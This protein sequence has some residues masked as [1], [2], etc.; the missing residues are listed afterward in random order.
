M[1]IHILYNF[2][3]EPWGGGNQFLK[4]LRSQ[5]Q[6]EGVYAD[7]LV[8]ADV[9]LFNS[10]PFRAERFFDEV[11]KLKKAHPEKLIVYRLNGPISFI[12]GKD[13]ALDRIIKLYNELFVDGI[14]FQ[15]AWCQRKNH[16]HFE[17]RS[18][19]EV[20][21]HNAPD[22]KVFYPSRDKE[23]SKKTRLIATSWSTNP[24][25]GFDLY[26]F[27]DQNLDLNRFD[28]TFVGNSPIIFNRIKML[29]PMNSVDLSYELRAHDIYITASQNDPCSNALIE[30]L[31]CGLPSVALNGGGHPEL[32]GEGGAVF[33]GE[34]DVLQVIDEVAR[35]INHYQRALPT[36][37]IK[38]TAKE[39]VLFSKTILDNAQSNHYTPKRIDL[40]TRFAF[41]KLKLMI[42]WWKI[43][44]KWQ[45]IKTHVRA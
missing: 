24:R 30:A 31:A 14:I 2:R 18:D 11:Y 1:K 27:L 44:N 20:V 38:T 45:A 29:A 32:V 13:A 42:L 43:G 41:L 9:I 19:Y 10:Y 33:E 6:R 35:R 25:K 16:E 26:R 21:I 7:K 22:D 17:I 40:Y 36:F 34:G 4:A 3:D 5:W 15:S 39:Y 28:M 12:R 37:S 23:V 8:D